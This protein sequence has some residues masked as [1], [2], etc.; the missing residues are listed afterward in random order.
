MSKKAFIE[1]I[2]FENSAFSDSHAKLVSNLLDEVSKG[3]Y[4][5]GH[6]FVYEL[7]QNADDAALGGDN[8][9]TFIFS[10][11]FLII[12]HNGKP[13]D[14]ADI[15]SLTGAGESTKK[16]DPTKTGYKGVGFKSV[17]AQSEKVFIFSEGFQFRFERD[18]HQ[19]RLPWQII[20][21]WTELSDLPIEIRNEIGQS[22]LSVI[23]V[24]ELKNTD[25]VYQHLEEL[26]KSPQILLFLRRVSKIAVQ[27]NGKQEY[28]V[29]K[30]IGQTDN[31]FVEVSLLK[32]TK[33][34]STWILKTFDRIAIPEDVK[35]KLTR[36]DPEKLREAEFAEISFAAKTIDGRIAELKGEESLIFTY[37]PTK[38]T[39]FGF[40]FLVNGNF[41][42]N[43]PREAIHQDRPWNQWFFELV[44]QKILDW[45]ELLGAT[46]F[47]FDILSLLPHK[48]N[49]SQNQ[50]KISFDKAFGKYSKT[51]EFIPNKNLNLKRASELIIDNT[52]LSEQPFIPLATLVNYV[53]NKTGRNFTSD[54]FV[55]SKV[56]EIT[57]IIPLGAFQF[58]LNSLEDFFTSDIFQASHA[59]EKNFQLI[60]Y[61]YKKSSEPQ[62]LDMEWKVRLQYVPFIFSETNKLKAP[63]V[64]R[65]PSVVTNPD[66]DQEIA[67]LSIEVHSVVNTEIEQHPSIKTWLEQ[68]GIKDSGNI[69]EPIVQDIENKITLD[70]YDKVT[71]YLFNQHKKG[72]LTEAHYKRLKNLKLLTKNINLVVASQC[73]LPNEYGPEFKFENHFQEE[74]VATNYIAKGD[75]VSEWNTFFTRIGVCDSVKW[76]NVELDYADMKANSSPYLDYFNKERTYK[77]K[78]VMYGT[79]YDNS[80]DKYSINRISRI[81]DA[82]DY[83]FSKVFWQYVL[84]KNLDSVNGTDHGRCGYFKDR[85]KPLKILPFNEW[86]ICN[87]PIIPTTLQ[88]CQL[89]NEVFINEKELKDL[90]GEYL[91]VFD[92][93]HPIAEHWREMLQLKTKLDVGDYLKL[94]DRICAESIREGKA[95]GGKRK[96]IGIIYNK[97]SLLLPDLSKEKKELIRA[98]AAQTKLLASNGKFEPAS[99]LKWVKIDGFNIP[100][101]KLMS[102]YFP[103]TCKTDSEHLVELMTL[104]NVQI[105]TKFTP[106]VAD[107]KFD[108]SFKQKFKSILPSFVALIEKKRYADS[109]QEFERIFAIINKTEFFTTSDIKLSFVHESD[110]IEGPSLTVYRDEDTFYYKGKWKSPLTMFAFLPE[111]T[112]LLDVSNLASELRLLLEEDDEDEIRNWLVSQGVDLTT[113]ISKREFAAPQLRF[114]NMVS[115]VNEPALALHSE[116]KLSASQSPKTIMIPEVGEFTLPE[117]FTPKVAASKAK[118]TTIQQY[119]VSSFRKITD[120]SGIVIQQPVMA[121]IE[122]EE[123]R[124]EVGRWS[125][126]YVYDQLIQTP[127]FSNVIWENK[128]GESGKPW[129]FKVIHNGKEK[130]IDVKGTPSETKSVVYLSPNEWVFMMQQKER[131]SIFRLYK[132]GQDKPDIVEFNNPALAVTQGKMLPN[133]TTLD[134]NVLD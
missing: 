32:D 61:F 10:K 23:T 70:N 22:K 15:K 102:V 120:V 36:D 13:F 79:V 131:Y 42:T 20:P 122:S 73:L 51:K 1:S 96:R 92:Y 99:D 9:V 89:A 4:S 98:A 56:K 48:F 77:Y 124:L 11:N 5:E 84:D 50:L 39:E 64:L 69:L 100:P 35:S 34:V 85:Y 123:A 21:V 47:K 28:V 106:S 8:E 86:V 58:D 111:L 104:L 37:L 91:P 103:D 126:K 75:V 130:F 45:L 19:K 93:E 46:K 83:R 116:K 43:T 29:E 33:S 53:N 112:K 41:I 114:R 129:D 128:D 30:K 105:I 67:K 72:L 71:R 40:S 44:A 117:V 81:A 14:E 97:L 54:S 57:K 95:K 49:S 66:T 82:V 2:L 119:K 74:Y 7:V 127:E 60:E 76:E 26:L 59:P 132:A 62:Y 31:A 113:L 27:K 88:T 18:Y 78:S 87:F 52:G 24:I 109:H 134:V 125:E 6:R 101:E 12:G 68:L 121:V 55:H 63:N 94:L 17:F 90:A 118:P 115:I 107:Q 65:F 25:L 133:P 38:V 16:A 80:F 3:I 110:V 108:P